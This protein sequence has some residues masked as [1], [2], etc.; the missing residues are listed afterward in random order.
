M[1]DATIY[2][3]TVFPL[4]HIT[5]PGMT[6]Y[7]A[8]RN[9]IFE[10]VAE[11]R[12]DREPL[13]TLKWLAYEKWENQNKDLPPF[14]C[15]HCASD[16]ATLTYDAERGPCPSCGEE[17]L[18]TD[19]LGFHLAMAQD[20]APDSIASEYI[21]IHETLLLFTGIRHFWENKPELLRQCLFLK[22][23]PLAIRAQYSK[24]VAPIRRFIES[25]KDKGIEVCI[26]GQEKSGAFFD[27]LALIGPSA[28]SP[29]LFVPGHNYIREEIQHRPAAGAPYGF[30]TNYGAKVFA[31]VNE[32]HQA[33]LNI[34]TG[35]YNSDP[36]VSDL[37]GAARIFATLPSLLSSRYEGGLFPIELAHNIAS[38]S[39]YPS[40]KV[41]AMFA[42]AHS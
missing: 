2:H 11:D 28:P 8:I 29:M 4:R 39:T 21:M 7:N 42:E 33:V 17:I 15:P 31:K 13:E 16:S 35:A 22:D 36:A 3:A 24:L 9:G 19:M 37:V 12:L 6:I 41:L 5:V 27:H 30:D 40:A 34:P 23:G 18:L 32:R 1:A 38:L 14:Q 26:L 20:S 10:S 25:A